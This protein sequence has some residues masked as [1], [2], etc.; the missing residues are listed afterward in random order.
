MASSLMWWLRP[1]VPALGRLRQEDG[2]FQANLNYRKRDLVSMKQC[3]TI[4][5]VYG[6]V[7]T[8][9][10]ALALGSQ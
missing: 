3:N 5:S 8:T 2:A 4:D 7:F 10:T 6:R 1:V 9:A